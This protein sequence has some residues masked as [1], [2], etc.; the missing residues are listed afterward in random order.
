MKIENSK[1][2]TP[3][4]QDAYEQGMND[5]LNTKSFEDYLTDTEI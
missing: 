1:P 5:T 4:I 3:I 2:L